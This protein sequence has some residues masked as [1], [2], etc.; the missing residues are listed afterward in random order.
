[1]FMRFKGIICLTKVNKNQTQT[2]RNENTIIFNDSKI[3]ISDSDSLYIY[4]KDREVL[5][6]GSGVVNKELEKVD[7]NWVNLYENCEDEVKISE[8]NIDVFLITRSV[9]DKCVEI[10]L[11]IEDIYRQFKLK[12]LGFLSS[13]LLDIE[14]FSVL[15]A[16]IV[17]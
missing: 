17:E 9:Y 2:E 7:I 14:D 16:Q 11:S 12:G 4:M 8:S 10:G 3:E 5:L 13:D 1:M 15:K 6:L